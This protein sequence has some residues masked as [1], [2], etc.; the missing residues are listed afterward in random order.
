[1]DYRREPLVLDS[2]LFFEITYS[3]PF[4]S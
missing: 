4:I 2:I 1:L 3:N